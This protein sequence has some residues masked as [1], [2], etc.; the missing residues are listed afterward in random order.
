MRNSRVLAACGATA[1]VAAALAGP[2]GSGSA[3]A[4]VV[5]TGKQDNYLHSN[6][7]PNTASPGQPKECEA[8]NETFQR[9]RTVLSNPPGTQSGKTETTKR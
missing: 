7:Y 8:G 1:L 5:H 2:A 6:P 3:S 4:E 9:G